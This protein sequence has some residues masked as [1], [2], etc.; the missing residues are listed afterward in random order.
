MNMPVDVAK[1]R[2]ARYAASL[3]ENGMVVGLGSGSTAELAVRALGERVRAGLHVV[4]VPTSRR[5][6]ALARR[7]GLT[8]REPEVVDRVDLAI[9]GADEVEPVRLGL[10]KGRGGALV[11]EK[12]VARWADRVV[13]VVDESKLVPRLGS[14]FPVPVE[15]VPFGW[16]WCAH[17]LEALGGRVALRRRPDGRPYRS[18]NGNLILDVQFDGIEE[19]GQLNVAIKHLPGVVDHGLFLDLADLVIVGSATEVRLL[20]RQI[21]RR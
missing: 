8:V 12:L 19:P 2:A 13:I 3:V 4:G 14:R 10:L 6:A 11:R 1:E 16:S 7:L 5:T 17:W 20:Q 21:A 18:D 9:D 15:V